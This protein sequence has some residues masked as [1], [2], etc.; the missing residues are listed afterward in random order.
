MCFGIQ[1]AHSARAA[2]QY[3]TRNLITVGD[4][5][6]TSTAGLQD[7][8]NL[9]LTVTPTYYCSFNGALTSCFTGGSGLVYFAKVVV[10]GTFHS[11]LN[12]PGIPNT[13]VV[14]STAVM[15]VTNQ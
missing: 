8:P 11:M 5:T 3:Q 12:Y 4:R 15:R 13:A 2:L 1:V 6:G 7:A 14:T 10:S 9:G